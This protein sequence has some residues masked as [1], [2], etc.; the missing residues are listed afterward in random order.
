[1]NRR[2]IDK[3]RNLASI[4]IIKNLVPIAD[5]DR[6]ELAIIDG[7]Q[8]IV[9]KDEYKIG[10]MTVFCEIDSVLPERQEFEFLRRSKFR[11]KTM[12]MAGV[13][14]QGICFNLDILPKGKYEIDQDVTA[15]LGIKQYETT[16]D[17]GSGSADKSYGTKS[18]IVK[19]LMRYA[20][21]R[22][23]FGGLFV[24]QKVTM[25]F[26]KFISK[27]DETRIQNIPHVLEDKNTKWI[28]REKLDGQSGT[29]FLKKK[30]LGRYDFGV[31]SRN[32]QLIEDDS[33]YW[34]IAKS[35][36][37]K[38]ILQKLI[39][40]HRWVAI[41]GEILGPG[42]QKNKYKFNELQIRVFNLVFPTGKARCLD[43]EERIMQLGLKWCPLIDE[44]YILPE[45]VN[46][47]L[48]FATGSSLEGETLREGLVFRNYT[49][50]HSFKAVSPEFLIKNDE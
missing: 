42:I 12:K 43:W 25:D 5:R 11:I 19:K 18:K 8:I 49:R 1:M 36:N 10:D 6:I 29:F 27:T 32:L 44:S 47:L 48:E 23:I 7:W 40:E 33:N 22:K 45:T 26:P 39:G 17:K 50:N 13:L 2:E 15:L 46:E 34:Q 20:M 4:K 14:S 38:E 21:F 3:M 41:Q 35:H 24:K 28:V 31:C 16:I 9:K 30:Y 37:I